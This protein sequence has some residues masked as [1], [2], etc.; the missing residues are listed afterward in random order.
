MSTTEYLFVS[1]PAGETVE[2][3]IDGNIYTKYLDFNV[4]D[5]MGFI[6]GLGGSSL[7]AKSIDIP[8]LPIF[9]H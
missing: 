3:V 7:V 2:N 6:V 1:S 5:G 9:S 8:T 4:E